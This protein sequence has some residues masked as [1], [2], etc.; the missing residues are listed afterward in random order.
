MLQRVCLAALL[1]LAVSDRLVGEDVQQR[2][3]PYWMLLHEPA[4]VE[5]LQ[6]DAAQ[7]RDYQTLLD[8][9][10]VE[11][12][13]LRNRQ[14]E[15]AYAGLL[16]LVEEAQMELA[17]ILKP[18]QAERLQQ[19][20]VWRLGDA[21]FLRESVA[22]KMRYTG[23]Q[24][25]RIE[26]IIAD[27]EQAAKPLYEA[28]NRGEPP[29]PIEEEYRELKAREQRDL[30]AVLTPGQRAIWQDLHG[31]PFDVARLGQPR[32]KAPE[33]LETGEWVNG[34]GGT[35]ASLRGRVVVVHFYACGCINC[36]R[37]YPWYR[38][39]QE[40]Y[41][42]QPFSL[43]GIHTPEVD[44]E[45]RIENVRRKAAE[46]RLTFPIL[47]DGRN[48]NWNA[49]GNSMWPS[50][51]V[52]DKEGRLRHFWAGELKW[53]GMDGERIA[54]DRIE[55]LLRETAGESRTTGASG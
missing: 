50:V 45:R 20:Q 34:T 36:I 46:E 17:K 11:Y 7:A 35:L 47:I 21:A 2:V 49:W 32:F 48:E 55:E 10:D 53:Q 29:G 24:R 42:D 8:R 27:A 23:D 15:E 52:I 19:L 30:L 16:K 33:F 43:I 6:L 39:W 18:K 12:F 38:D 1:A 5:A 37:N 54:R 28:R 44:D 9:L 13:P 22:A 41:A 3:D 51:Y 25:G 4:V 14:R 40:R 31:A 26:R